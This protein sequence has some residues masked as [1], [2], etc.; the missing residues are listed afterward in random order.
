[1]NRI[2]CLLVAAATFVAPIASAATLSVE[3]GAGSMATLDVVGSGVNNFGRLSDANGPV[4]NDLG[5]LITPGVTEVTVFRQANAETGG[6]FLNGLGFVTITFL[7][8]EAGFMN[9]VSGGGS[10]FA[11][12]TAVLGDSF[13]FEASEGY[14]DFGFTR[15]TGGGGLAANNN[16]FISFPARLAFSSVF[17]GGTSVLAFFEDLGADALD[18]DD[19]VVRIDVAPIP[20]PASVWLFGSALAGLTA[21]GRRRRANA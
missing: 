2:S 20:L 3:T 6:L 10:S 17:N 16:G 18:Y 9:M 21:L 14:I 13:T 5:G 4:S 11:T 8:A 15:V 19:M 7:G 1:M 12:D